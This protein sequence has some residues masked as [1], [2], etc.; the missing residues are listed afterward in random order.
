MLQR[1][2]VAISGLE[3]HGNLIETVL[4]AFADAD[5]GRASSFSCS[6]VPLLS[7]ASCYHTTNQIM[8][9]LRKSSLLRYGSLLATFLLRPRILCCLLCGQRLGTVVL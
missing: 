6:S 9:F 2:H 1:I 5:V 3:V 7:C 4:I 8:L